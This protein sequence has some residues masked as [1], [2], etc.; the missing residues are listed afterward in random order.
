MAGVTEIKR[1]AAWE[2]YDGPGGGAGW[3]NLST[4]EIRRQDARPGN[5][6]KAH[7]SRMVIKRHMDIAG[8][9]VR[10]SSWDQYKGP[11]DGDGWKH[12]GTG[13]VRYQ[14]DQP[15]DDDAVGNTDTDNAVTGASDTSSAV[16]K[17]GPAVVPFSEIHADPKRFQYKIEGINES[18]V[19]DQFDS[20]D[21]NPAFAGMLYVWNDPAD[22]KTY[23]VNGNHRYQL[24]KRSRYSG[25]MAVYFIDRPNAEEARAFGALVNIA[26]KQGT[27]M[28]AANFFRDMGMTGR[29][30]LAFF[31]KHNISVKN[32]LARDSMT[33]A[34]L[35]D[36]VFRE[37]RYRRLQMGHALAI[38]AELKPTGDKEHD[39][40]IYEAQNKLLKRIVSSKRKLSNSVVIEMAIN[41]SMSPSVRK[42]TGSQGSLF[43][44]DD[45]EELLVEDR[46]IVQ[47]FVRSEMVK[48]VSGFGAVSSQSRENLIESSG[49]GNVSSE[50]ANEKKREAIRALDQF[51]SSARL[52][53]GLS[54]EVNAVLNEAAV[55]HR[56]AANKTVRNRIKK[57]ALEK[58]AALIESGLIESG[59]KEFAA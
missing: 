44:S 31:K 43:G 58:I 53:G 41:Y 30:G 3:K 16:R 42:D 48:R 6:E 5:V 18:G 49:V 7:G 9:L 2:Q 11:R 50:K 19:T 27:A 54:Q 14:D 55:A 38:G 29:E 23:V 37:L 39:A 59:E 15:G 10:M 32:S 25:D 47:S 52:K 17:K 13:E 24:A 33:L 22:G 21:Y 34:N 4:G 51:A 36:N 12:S 46:S 1:I 40:A 56:G 26:E 35:S 20:I 45:E 57:S 28:D 8:D